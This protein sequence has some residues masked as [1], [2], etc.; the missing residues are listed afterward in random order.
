VEVAVAANAGS[1]DP[2]I[3]AAA[4]AVVSNQIVNEDD[5]ANTT[6]K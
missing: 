6:G 5:E 4:A 3:V 2:A 1:T